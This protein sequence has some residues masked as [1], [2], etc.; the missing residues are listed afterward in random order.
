MFIVCIYI[1]CHLI[2]YGI[3]DIQYL[4]QCND[5]V[6]AS[7]LLHNTEAHPRLKVNNKDAIWVNGI[8]LIYLPHKQIKA[9]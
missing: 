4:M 1:L 9:C 2:I 5:I 6:M 8:L 7:L 3:I